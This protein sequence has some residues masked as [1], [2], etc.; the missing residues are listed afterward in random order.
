M[1]YLCHIF[2]FLMIFLDIILIIADVIYLLMHYSAVYVVYG[3][4][5]CKNLYLRAETKQA[6]M[7]RLFSANLTRLVDDHIPPPHP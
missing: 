2:D 3:H 7:E 6:N 4:K 1:H 5:N